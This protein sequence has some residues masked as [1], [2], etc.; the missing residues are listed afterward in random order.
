MDFLCSHCGKD[1][2]EKK[3]F[4]AHIRICSDTRKLHCKICDKEYV[5]R[6]KL[7]T[8]MASHR[9]SCCKL[10]GK[11]VPANSLQFHKK[12]CSEV[13]VNIFKCDQCNFETNQKGSLKKHK[14]THIQKEKPVN[15]CLLCNKTFAKKKYLKSHLKTHTST[16]EAPS[17]VEIKCILCTKSFANQQNLNRHMKSFHLH[18]KFQNSCGYGIYEDMQ[19]KEV[20]PKV[21]Q[22]SCDKCEYSN[23][24]QN[25]LKRHMKTHDK[26]PLKKK[27]DNC[28]YTSKYT[29]DVKKH[30]KRGKCI[31]VT[32]RT[33]YRQYKK[34][35][36]ELN[37]TEK[38]EQIKVF[39]E[40]GVKRL[41][42]DCNGSLND[43]RK[44]I[45]WMRHAFGRKAFTPKINEIIKQ[46]V[47][48]LRD[49]HKA[50][51]ATFK[52]KKG[53]DFETVLSTVIDLTK[54]IEEVA[55]IRKI[56]K[57]KVILGCDGGQNKCIVTIIVMDQDY[58]K[59]EDNDTPEDYKPTGQKRVQVAAKVD[60]VPETRH[61]VE[62]LLGSLNL[63][64]LEEDF[65][66][67]CDLKLCNLILGIQSCTAM[68][69]CP[70]CEGFKIDNN[71]V[72]TNGRGLWIPK[73][74]RTGDNI[75]ANKSQWAIETNKNRKQLKNYKSCEFDP[76]PLRKDQG[77]QE[78]IFLLPPDP[79][80][81]NLLG[82]CND[83]LEKMENLWPVEMKEEFYA[84]HHLSKSGGG[85]GGQFDGPSIKHIL[86]EESLIDLEIIL[87]SI[88]QTLHFTNYLRS[89]RKLH[90]MCIAPKLENYSEVIDEYTSKFFYLYEHFGLNMTLKVHVII[91]HYKYFF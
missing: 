58:D 88:E 27:C 37:I 49:L 85:P 72:R 31:K 90:M 66:L 91:D 40:E 15:T 14:T 21:I 75:S 4:E 20:K 9:N 62:I 61:N 76:I 23:T 52:D 63:P 86:K 7:Y 11:S 54:F 2:E 36:K 71:N 30:M 8:H 35:K 3:T 47:N 5:G 78:V 60:E 69:G 12:Q 1:Y 29:A 81:I 10:C 74:M 53:E 80:H 67:V 84:K 45:K 56:E 43:L 42:D 13:E 6:Q 26:E 16:K 89:I 87:P 28:E 48:S 32:K 79:L 83:I 25:N 50:E 22:H 51:K 82:P 77:K 39:N 68:Y 64:D 59:D 70:Y 34:L 46:H 18:K 55:L 41:I 19:T 73:E 24:R 44:V 65:Q 17:K 33:K 38:M 57:P